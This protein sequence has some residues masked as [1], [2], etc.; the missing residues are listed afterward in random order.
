MAT[1]TR[2]RSNSVANFV[3]VFKRTVANIK[4]HRTIKALTVQT[5]NAWPNPGGPSKKIS[6][7]VAKKKCR[8]A[9]TSGGKSLSFYVTKAKPIF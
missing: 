8:V 2:I 6:G 1:K 3:D 5:N 4:V 9:S 7:I